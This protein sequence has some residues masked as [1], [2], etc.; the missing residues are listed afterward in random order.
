MN[1]ALPRARNPEPVVELKHATWVGSRE[2]F[3]QG[4]LRVSHFVSS[5]SSSTVSSIHQFYPFVLWAKPLKTLCF[6]S[7]PGHRAERERIGGL[8]HIFLH[9][10]HSQGSLIVRICDPSVQL[11]LVCRA[12]IPGGALR[13]RGSR[14]RVCNVYLPLIYCDTRLRVNTSDRRWEY[15]VTAMMGPWGAYVTSTFPDAQRAPV[16]WLVTF[17][18]RPVEATVIPLPRPTDVTVGKPLADIDAS[19]RRSRSEHP[20]KRSRTSGSLHEC[21]RRK[22]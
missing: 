13:F 12:G 1:I 14:W 20:K 22:R 2:I 4:G 19:A 16:A 18:I 8:S 15:L 11:G 6:V 5:L 10:Q 21:R 3:K 9:S 17:V 7:I